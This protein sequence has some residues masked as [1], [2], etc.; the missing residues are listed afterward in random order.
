METQVRLP[1]RHRLVHFAEI[2]STNAEALRRAAAGERGPTWIWADRQTHGRGRLG[3]QWV[4]ETGNLYAT[5]LVSMAIELRLVAG[6][7]IVAPLAVLSTFRTYLPPDTRLEVKWPNDVIIAGLKAAGIL[8]ESTVQGEGVALAIGCGLNLLHAP[9]ASRYGA[10]TL[11]A[12]GV[13]VAP[14]QALERLA[15]E[16]D[17][18]LRQWNAGKGFAALRSAWLQHARGIGQL[19]SITVGDRTVR[20]YLEGL[21]DNGGL[22]LRIPSGVQEFHAGEISFADL[23]ES[24]S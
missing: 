11:A 1:P 14:R 18:L 8:V 13:K 7:S 12:H 21:G 17:S 24:G 15:A 5:L 23:P 19:V 3:R 20:G 4:S 2:D 16:M 10:T 22:L 6:L 9:D